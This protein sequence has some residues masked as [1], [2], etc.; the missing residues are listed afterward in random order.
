MKKAK[1]LLIGILGILFIVGCSTRY[2]AL[3][4]AT[5]KNIDI[6]MAQFEKVQDG[7]TGKS[8][9]PII[10]FIPTGT[11]S[12]E[13][14]IDA[15]L[16]EVGGDIMQNV[17]IYY[18]WF[19]IPYVYGEYTFEVKGDV[20][21]LKNTDTGSIDS[22]VIDSAEQ[23]YSVSTEDGELTVKKIEDVGLAINEIL[24]K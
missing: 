11:P 17:V 20:W 7:V 21:K 23:I 12:I 13:D 5:T 19:Y 1:L 24:S 6:N 4:V 10:I 16:Q 3:T 22:K 9:K 8:T 18:K 2:G 14:A 15:A